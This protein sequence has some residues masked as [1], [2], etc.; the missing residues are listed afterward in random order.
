MLTQVL[1]Q[2][3]VVAH[4]PKVPL[5]GSSNSG[6]SDS[7]PEAGSSLSSSHSLPVAPPDHT[8]TCPTFSISSVATSSVASIHP[9]L[10]ATSTVASIHLP[11]ATASSVASNHPP[12]ATAP[13]S[14]SSPVAPTPTIHPPPVAGL[15]RASTLPTITGFQVCSAA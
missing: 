1:K 7:L 13:S 8:M 6:S 2:N 5:P 11:T 4:R 14:S 12:P 15:S 9:P 3:V 10:M